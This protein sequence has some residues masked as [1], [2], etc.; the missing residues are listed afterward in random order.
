LESKK[1]I[2][3]NTS[4]EKQINLLSKDEEDAKRER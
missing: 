1:D 4:F 2:V 3:E